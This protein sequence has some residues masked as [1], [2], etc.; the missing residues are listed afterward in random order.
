MSLILDAMEADRPLDEI[1]E[2]IRANPDAVNIRNGAGWTP[3][4]LCINK[5]DDATASAVGR[6]NRLF[7]QAQIY[8]LQD[9]T[10][11]SN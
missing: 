4:R 5:F 9:I 2:V 10:L 8:T 7:G 1:M 3:L 6:T 11:N